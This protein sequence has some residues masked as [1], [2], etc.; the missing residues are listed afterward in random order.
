MGGVYKVADRAMHFAC[1]TAGL[2]AACMIVFITGAVGSEVLLRLFGLPAFGWA[3]ELSEFG[4]V[5]VSFLGAP[6][7]LRNQEH[8]SVDIV[9]RSVRPTTARVL[10][11]IADI[12]SAT[13]CLILAQFAWKAM[14]EALNRGSILYNYFATPQWVIL[15]ILPIGALL[16]AIEFGLRIWRRLGN[17]TPED[18]EGAA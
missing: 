5:V 18:K 2:L 4:L 8:I 15:A 3:L 12:I 14:S 6:W 1:G 7:V 11:T 10:L 9:M 17:V 16:L 13:A